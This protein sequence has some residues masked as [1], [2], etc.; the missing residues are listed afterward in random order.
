MRC[1]RLPIQERYGAPIL[2]RLKKQHVCLFD[3]SL[4][5]FYILVSLS[6]S[7]SL[8]LQNAFCGLRCLGFLVLDFHVFLCNLS[9]SSIVCS[10]FSTLGAD[11]RCSNICVSCSLSSALQ[12][13]R[14]GV[15]TVSEV[16]VSVSIRLSFQAFCL[17]LHSAECLIPGATIPESQALHRG[18]F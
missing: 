11:T 18:V 12:D 3:L 14:T 8:V 5:V 1:F 15:C 17:R 6:L 13:V 7:C 2:V 9:L 16:C 4:K 10:L